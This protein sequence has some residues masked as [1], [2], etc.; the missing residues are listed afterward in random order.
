M[1]EE[2]KD[3]STA[4]SQAGASFWARNIGSAQEANALIERA[5][6]AASPN[7]V[8]QEPV[9]IGDTAVI[10]CNELN[11]GVGVGYG[12]GS[13]ADR[14]AGG[15]GGGGGGGSMGRP[16]AVI[17]IRPD[18]VKVEPII[19]LTKLGIA[20]LSTLIALIMARR[21]VKR[22]LGGR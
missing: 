5:L 19:D 10:T 3:G 12:G 2:E 22:T 13:D 4:G 15:A 16:V 1:A 17:S 14:Q 9:V 8:F 20:A 21:E 7:A 18:G 6:E 11:V